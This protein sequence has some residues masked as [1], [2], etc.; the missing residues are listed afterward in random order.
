MAINLFHD[1]NTDRSALTS[2]SSKTLDTTAATRWPHS[3]KALSQQV[4]VVEAGELACCRFLIIGKLLIL[5]KANNAQN[6]LFAGPIH[7]KFTLRCKVIH[8]QSPKAR[9]LMAGRQPKPIHDDADREGAIRRKDRLP[10][11]SDR[12]DAKRQHRSLAWR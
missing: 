9:S 2:H 4:F 3:P 7:V 1:P 5:D 8:G 12:N 10:P 11:Y 6:F